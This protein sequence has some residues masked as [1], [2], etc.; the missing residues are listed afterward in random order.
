MLRVWGPLVLCLGLGCGPG[1]AQETTPAPASTSTPAATGGMNLDHA[2][3][4]VDLEKRHA[5]LIK[6]NGP[7][8]DAA[9]RD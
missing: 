1:V 7:G 4:A 2:E 8:T 5:E 6:R 3:W 9:L